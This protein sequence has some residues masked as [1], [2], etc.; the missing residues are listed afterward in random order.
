MKV[1]NM[2]SYILVYYY[3][4]VYSLTY[5]Q[6]V[7]GVFYCTTG[8]STQCKIDIV[9]DVSKTTVTPKW[10][11]VNQPANG[12]VTYDAARSTSSQGCF[13]YQHNGGVWT[14]DSF[15]VKFTNACN[16]TA[17]CN[18]PIVKAQP[19]THDDEDIVVFLD[20]TTFS[21][22]DAVKIKATFNAL[23]TSLVNTFNWTGDVHY[24]PLGSGGSGTLEP[25][26]YIKHIRGLIDS[27]NGQVSTSIDI[28]AGSGTWDT[29]KSL[30]GYFSSNS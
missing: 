4:S 29:W 9:G 11:I 24:I 15:T 5:L 14:S 18:V 8:G 28:A 16:T 10:T 13:A 21:Y 2:Y 19:L 23:K 22:S 27:Q 1:L 6:I 20:T 7:G 26:D 3:F 12:T 30:P 25:G 17:I